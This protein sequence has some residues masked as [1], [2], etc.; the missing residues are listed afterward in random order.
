MVWWMNSVFLAQ[1]STKTIINCIPLIS[2]NDPIFAVVRLENHYNFILDIAKH[3][4]NATFYKQY[5]N[6]VYQVWRDMVV[7]LQKM[8]C[9]RIYLYTRLHCTSRNQYAYQMTILR[10]CNIF[11]DRCP[12]QTRYTYEITMT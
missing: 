1:S 5:L 11:C 12:Q 8:K 3:F 7:E 10:N 9:H 2:Y 6:V 4:M